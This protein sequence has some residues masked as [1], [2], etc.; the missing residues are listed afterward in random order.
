MVDAV[1]NTDSAGADSPGTS[2]AD[3]K[4]QMT[5][6]LNVLQEYAK[7]CLLRGYV[8]P[9]ESEAR[10]IQLLRQLFELAPLLNL[11]DRDAVWLLYNGLFSENPEE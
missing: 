2:L 8:P 11:T 4:E 10:R 1:S 3:P 6:C 5:L 9:E 7:W